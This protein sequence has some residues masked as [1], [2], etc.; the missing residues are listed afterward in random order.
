M[1][2]TGRPIAGSVYWRFAHFLFPFWT[3][4]PDGLFR[5][6]IVARAW[7][8]MDDTHTMFVHLSWKKNTPG[9][10]KMKDGSPIP[11]RRHGAHNAAQRHRAGTGAGGS[12]PT[13]QTIT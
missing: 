2:P 3:M 13:Q 11:G 9:L 12:P 1:P 7:V 4:P 8:P 10:R 5:D 6:H